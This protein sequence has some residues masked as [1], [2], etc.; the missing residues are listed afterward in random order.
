MKQSLKEKLDKLSQRVKKLSEMLLSENITKDMEYYTS[1]NKEYAD[2]IPIVDKYNELLN[3]QDNL[4]S[5]NDLL[6][7]SELKDY[8]SAEIELIKI[9]IDNLEQQLQ[10]LLLPKDPNDEKN[11][12]IEIRAGTGGDESA[13]FCASLFRMYSD[14]QK[15]IIG[16]L[17]L[18]QSQFQ[19]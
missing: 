8:A 15:E 11:I 6:G 7:D 1:L 18:F 13:L 9:N 16:K 19:I 17:K 3:N 5:A 4:K 2:L 14:L 10:M 12:Y